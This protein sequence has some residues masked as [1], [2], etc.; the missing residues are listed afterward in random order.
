MLL[1]LQYANYFVFEADLMENSDIGLSIYVYAGF[2]GYDKNIEY[3]FANRIEG[4]EETSYHLLNKIGL[5]NK[6][7]VDNR[8]MIEDTITST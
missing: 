4:F 6:I 3:E 7:V 5:E 2:I 1:K 8:F